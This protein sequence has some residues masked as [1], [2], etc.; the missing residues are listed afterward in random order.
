MYK[1]ATNSLRERLLKRIDVRGLFD[2][3]P[4]QGKVERN[5]YGRIRVGGRSSPYAPSHRVAY[6]LLKENGETYADDDPRLTME[7]DHKCENRLCH[8]PAHLQLI[9]GHQNR[10]YRHHERDEK[11]KPPYQHDENEAKEM[12][13]YELG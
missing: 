4:W 10:W 11:Y 3:W 12:D 5:G 7:V 1:D 9:P 6:W 2:C 8:N 13:R